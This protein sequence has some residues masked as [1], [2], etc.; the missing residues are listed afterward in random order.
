MRSEMRVHNLTKCLPLVLC[1]G[2]ATAPA[3]GEEVKAK[4]S[5]WMAPP[6]RDNGRC[7]RE[8]FDRPDEWKETRSLVDVL[9]YA[10]HNLK[11]QFNDEEMR[12]WF[13]QLNGW[14]LKFGMEVGAIK[15]WGLTG[16]KTFNA[17]KPNWDRLQGLGASLYA[18]AMDEPLLCCREHIHKPD[19]YAV[20]ETASYIALVRKHFPQMLIGDIETYPS[21]PVPDHVWWIDALNKRLAEMGVRGLDFYRVDVNWANFIVQNHGTWGEVRKI[22]QQCRARKLPFSLIYWASGQPLL[23]RKGL[24]D[25]STWYISIMHQGYS[26]AMVD[27]RPDQYVIESWIGAPARCVPE[28]DEWSFT[29]SVRDFAKR[30]VARGP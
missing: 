11:K 12:K 20:Q 13:G 7:F 8:L 26:Y 9:F 14:K 10:D 29:R 5:V 23:Q 17:E 21:I 28:T 1:L 24:A 27:G 18:I 30:F 22:E 25:D 15:P 2:A 4:P 3:L 6:G 19:D 16:E